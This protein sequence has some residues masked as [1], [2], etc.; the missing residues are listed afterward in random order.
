MIIVI[1]F[2]EDP[3]TVWGQTRKLKLHATV[4]MLL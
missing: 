4:N 1:P 2:I 3:S